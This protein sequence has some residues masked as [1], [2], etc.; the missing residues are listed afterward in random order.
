LALYNSS[1]EHGIGSTELEYFHST[2]HQVIAANISSI[3]KNNV[4]DT[5]LLGCYPVDL[6]SYQ[7]F[8]GI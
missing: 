5:C 3:R 6:Y 2:K 8:K 4:E 7:C 1:H